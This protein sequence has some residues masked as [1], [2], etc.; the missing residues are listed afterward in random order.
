MSTIYHWFSQRNVEGKVSL[1]MKSLVYFLVA[2]IVITSVTNYFIVDRQSTVGSNS[3]ALMNTITS[4]DETILLAR[5]HLRDYYIFEAANDAASSDNSKAKFEQYAGKMT[6][7]KDDYLKWYSAQ[8]INSTEIEAL[9]AQLQTEFDAFVAVAVNI[10]NLTQKGEMKEAA[11]RVSTDCHRTAGE[12][13]QTIDDIK[14]KSIEM[15]DQNSAFSKN[16]EIVLIVMSVL[17]LVLGI[18]VYNFNKVLMNKAIVKPLNDLRRGAEKLA[19]GE[20]VRLA[21]MENSHDKDEIAALVNSFNK[22]SEALSSEIKRLENENQERLQEQSRTTSEIED[23]RMM[24]QSGVDEMLNR[25]QDL[26]EGNLSTSS[27]RAVS[28]AAQD[29][30]IL[31]MIDT[32]NRS[33]ASIAGSIQKVSQSTIENI[34][35]AKKGASTIEQVYNTTSEV[36]TCAKEMAQS[37]ANLQ[38]VKEDITDIIEVINTIAEQTSLLALNASIEAARAG[39]QGRGFAVVADEVRVLA[40]KTVEATQKIEALITRL[41]EETEQSVKQVENVNNKITESDT[42]VKKANDALNSIVESSSNI[43][44]ALKAF[45]I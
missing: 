39:E 31:K 27:E 41:N 8:K 9:N 13:L 36:V 5:I 32:L 37:I 15:F 21:P 11:Y 44:V 43:E 14:A 34:D 12:L 16:A 38:T 42:L 29:E 23:K 33:K 10:S 7:I 19:N 28:H 17:L 4:L 45:N 22:M 3:Q 25:L 1:A 18:V 35:E 30:L 40:S 26:A 24:L 2:V 20:T 6:Q